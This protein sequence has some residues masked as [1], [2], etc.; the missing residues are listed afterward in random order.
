MANNSND[1]RFIYLVFTAQNRLRMYIRDELM[2]A[3]VKITLVQAGILFLLREK[4]YRTMSELGQHLS[5]DNSTITGLIDRLEKE[6]FVQRQANPKDR[7]ISLIHITPE[8][9]QEANQAKT[10]IN[11]VNNEIKADFSR[12]EMDAFKKILN[13]FVVKFK[14]KEKGL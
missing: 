3:K 6:G 13:S 1:D 7:L 2:A 8:G 10:I 4:D 12:E 14:K 9:I 5:L 11:R